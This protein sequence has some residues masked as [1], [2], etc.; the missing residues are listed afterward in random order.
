MAGL[1]LVAL[2][3]GLATPTPTTASTNSRYEAVARGAVYEA[4]SWLSADLTSR[5]R[6]DGASLLADGAFRSS[7][8]SNTARGEQGDQGFGENDRSVLAITPELGGD[9][10]ARAELQLLIDQLRLDLSTELQRPGLVCAE[11]YY[12]VSG[13]G[14]SLP[15]HMDERHEEAKGARGWAGTYRRSL[16]W[17]VYL[18][19]PGWDE[20]GWDAPGGAGGGGA[21]RAYVRGET[22][23]AA[24]GA[25]AQNLQVG[26]REVS[27]HAAG[28]GGAGDEPAGFV[29]PVFLDCFLRVRH[30]GLPE[31]ELYEGECP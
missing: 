20:P 28:G 21:L 16:S 25:H 31:A 30:P 13:A 5:L 29:E 12:S 19:E 8:L 11:Q 26:W 23:G 3:C 7:G 9:V 27:S 24:C 14:A 18:S 10:S 2:A 4:R 1:P 22:G 15:L 17:L 6:A